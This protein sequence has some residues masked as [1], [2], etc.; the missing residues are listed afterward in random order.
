MRAALLEAPG[1]PLTIADD[2]EVSAPRAGQVLVRVRHCGV[3]HSDLHVVDGTF[4]SGLPVILGHEAA[5]VVEEVGPGVA[6]VRRGDPVLLTPCPPC[7]RCYF[8]VRG[9]VVLCPDASAI[10]TG[11][12][13]DGTTGLARGGQTV[14]RGVGLGAFAERV[15]VTEAAVVRLPDD[16]PLEIACVLGCAIQT[17]VGAVLNTARVE[18]GATVLVV[19]AGGV[20]VAIVQGARLA[21]ASRIVV[22]DPSAE[23][24]ERARRFGATDVLDPAADDVAG[25]VL[26]M[27]GVGVDY[28]FEAVGRGALVET[29]MAA[30]RAGGTTVCVGAMPLGD[31]VRIDPAVVFVAGEKVLRGCLLGSSNTHREVP[32]LLALWRAGRLDLE[33]MITARRPLAE[34]DA[35]F[36]DLRAAR[37][38]RTVLDC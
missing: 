22:S 3:C 12:F 33:S 1:A 36:D 37:G 23:R 16:V 25:A 21:G 24:R 28:A 20:G 7:G 17:G 29:A 4:P 11:T 15:L 32:R 30:T 31:A 14:F 18:E 10:Q 38:L 9:Q 26:G 6:G 35:A 5:G 34:I 2:V 8:C 27:T 13:P 19:G